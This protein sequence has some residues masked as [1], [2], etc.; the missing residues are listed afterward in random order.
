M[1]WSEV[2]MDEI[3]DQSHY[4]I[5]YLKQYSEIS[6]KSDNI[7]AIYAGFFRKLFGLNY[8]KSNYPNKISLPLHIFERYMSDNLLSKKNSKKIN[9]FISIQFNEFKKSKL[10]REFNSLSE[11]IFYILLYKLLS[12]ESKLNIDKLIETIWKNKTFIS[13]IDSVIASKNRSVDIKILFI[14]SQV[15]FDLDQGIFEELLFNTKTKNITDQAILVYL[16]YSSEIINWDKYRK[17]I[18]TLHFN[19]ILEAI[20]KVK[21]NAETSLDNE[22]EFYMLGFFMYLSEYDKGIFLPK[23]EKILYINKAIDK[24]MVISRFR[25]VIEK[26]RKEEVEINSILYFIKLSTPLTIKLPMYLI[27]ILLIIEIILIQFLNMSWY[28]KLLNSI[29]II[30]LITVYF[31]NKLSKLLRDIR[32]EL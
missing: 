13:K 30:I 4:Y 8:R 15:N 19:T 2:T 9:D 6:N 22:L 28:L 11:S 1:G 18:I 16:S 25:N 23:K 26:H 3:K 17:E 7:D 20:K 5:E 32:N 24:N 27:S 21:L 14:L 29:I 12:G 31:N 10:D